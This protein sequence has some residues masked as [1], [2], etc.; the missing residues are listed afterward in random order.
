MKITDIRTIRLRYPYEK[1]IAD[2]LSCCSAREAL[3]VIIETDAGLSGLG[4]CAAFGANMNALSA[5]IEE[6]LKPLL[7]GEDPTI[8]EK[9]WLKMTWN[10][11]ANGRRGI[12]KAAISGIDIALWD[13]LGK[14]AGL[15]V[16]RLLG[17]VTDKVEGYASAGFYAEE[18]SLDD[19]KREIEGYL[20][21]GYSAFKMK[22][23]RTDR[24]YRMPLRF[25]KQ[26]SWLYTREADEK[27]VETVR[28]MLDKDHILMLDMNGTWNL[29]DVLDAE[30]FFTENHIYMIEEPIRSDDIDG[31][32]KLASE[33]KHVR[34][35]G[36]ESEQG[37]DR[38]RQFLEASALDVVQVN[39]GWSG[40]FTECRKIAA[41]SQ[42]YD[43]LFT[44]HTFF[45]AVLTAANVQFAASQ[46]NVPFIES[47]ENFNP[48]RTD[49]LKTPIAC[50]EHM[51]YLVPQEPGLGI[52][53]N[54]DVAERYAVK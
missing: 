23:G 29:E 9:L 28:S 49:L 32:A 22:V 48:L 2:G 15:P 37:L 6:Q 47:E 19:L 12:I 11:F 33:L 20:N 34:I 54:W 40:G 46:Y 53:L 50:D 39:L 42:A 5:I 51:N 35:A 44:P 17:A 52:E 36:V 1:M 24:N 16:S 41:L 26:G 13:L 14:S 30:D 18:K 3:L 25:M 10:N 31:Y 21:K 27:R 4:E 43:R 8:I 45:S 7:T 38:Y